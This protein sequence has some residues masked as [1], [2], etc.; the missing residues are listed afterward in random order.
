MEEIKLRKCD[1]GHDP[2]IGRGSDGNY[3]GI[4][5]G[6]CGA[7]TGASVMPKIFKAAHAGIMAVVI[8]NWNDKKLHPESPFKI[9]ETPAQAVGQTN[10][11]SLDH[12]G[13]E[14]PRQPESSPE[15]A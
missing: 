13:Q 6:N 10:L 14:I 4:Y 12:L 5:C 11:S 3:F 9:I 15:A 7:G 8:K 2:F 1:C